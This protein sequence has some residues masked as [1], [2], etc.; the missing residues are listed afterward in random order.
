MMAVVS[1]GRAVKSMLTKHRI[2][3]SRI[4]KR[5]HDGTPPRLFSPGS[6][7]LLF[8]D[9]A[10][11]PRVSR[12]SSIRPAETEARGSVTDTVSMII[13][14]DRTM[15]HRILD[16]SHHIAH[17]HGSPHRCTSQPVQTMSTVISFVNQHHDRHHESHTTV[18]KEVR[19]DKVF[20]GLVK[21][22][23]LVFF[24]GPKARMTGIPLKDFSRPPR[25]QAVDEVLQFFKP[26]KV[27]PWQ[28][29]QPRRPVPR[30]TARRMTQAMVPPV[31]SAWITPPIPRIGA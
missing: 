18:Y 16:L 3:R 8:A 20:I 27:V 6:P 17:L 30:T 31:S 19:A 1:P 15:D 23:L 13:R 24:P 7:S 5:I 9:P 2:S 26:R 21:T 25:F 4:G 11:P 10:E 14:K 28:K 22:L 12:I 29:L